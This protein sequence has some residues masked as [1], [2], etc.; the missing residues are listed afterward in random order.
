MTSILKT[1][2]PW[3]EVDKSCHKGV[4]MIVVWLPFQNF[5]VKIAKNLRENENGGV[6][7]N[8]DD[9]WITVGIGGQK[10]NFSK[11]TFTDLQNKSLQSWPKKVKQQQ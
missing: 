7:T 6:L 9:R 5:K 1:T 10:E 3:E 11:T 2:S 8:F 4:V